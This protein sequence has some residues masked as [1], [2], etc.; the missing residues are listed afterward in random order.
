MSMGCEC[1]ANGVRA[2]WRAGA[3]QEPGRE[4]VVVGGIQLQGWL[5]KPAL[6]PCLPV[7]S[8]PLP[9]FFF[10]SGLGLGAACERETPCSEMPG[11]L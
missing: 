10:P 1:K 5:G 11:L 3:G 8:V 9:S 7:E 4:R 2:G 6:I